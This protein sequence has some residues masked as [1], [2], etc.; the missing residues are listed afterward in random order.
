M[1]QFLMMQAAAG[2][3]PDPAPP[4]DAVTVGDAIDAV[5]Q[6]AAVIDWATQEGHIPVERGVHAGAMLMILRDYIKPLPIGPRADGTDRVGADLT[7][8]VRAIRQVGGER[9]LQG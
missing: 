6:L 8:L 4:R 9:G 5:L 3:V 1:M 7:E 2:N